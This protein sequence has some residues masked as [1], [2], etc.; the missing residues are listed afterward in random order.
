MQL[1]FLYL[2]Q[3]PVI[4]WNHLFEVQPKPSLRRPRHLYDG[5]RDDLQ[6]AWL[7]D[8]M[9]CREAE[10]RRDTYNIYVCKV[11]QVLQLRSLTHI[12]IE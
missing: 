2:L 5:L 7:I 4:G 10:L 9:A 6:C 1:H 11:Q 12:L 3:T 8:S